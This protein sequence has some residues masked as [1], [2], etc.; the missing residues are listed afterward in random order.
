MAG[1]LLYFSRVALVNVVAA[2]VSLNFSLKSILKSNFILNFSFFSLFFF[3]SS[4]SIVDCSINSHI[5]VVW[6]LLEKVK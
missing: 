6:T 4:L 5:T 1:V 3:F 2:L